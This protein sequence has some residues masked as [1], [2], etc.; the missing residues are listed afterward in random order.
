VRDSYCRPATG[1]DGVTYALQEDTRRVGRVRAAAHYCQ[2]AF[3]VSGHD[4][5]VAF[6]DKL[7]RSE[8]LSERAAPVLVDLHIRN[9]QAT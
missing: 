6:L 1:P 8:L 3:K 2:G 4:V 9:R 5:G 7:R